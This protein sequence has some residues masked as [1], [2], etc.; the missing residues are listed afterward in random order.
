MDFKQGLHLGQRLEQRLVMT[1]Q[2]QQAIRLLQLSRA[3]LVEQ[4]RETLNENPLLE[5]QASLDG[6][7]SSSTVTGG[8]GEVTSLDS[9]EGSERE[10]SEIDWQEYFADLARGPSAQTG[11]Y[12]SR[13]DELPPLTQTLTKDQTLAEE[14]HDQLAVSGLDEQRLDIANEVIGN[15]DD[16]GY[17]RPARLQLRGGSD[18]G[19]RLLKR[20]AEQ[21]GI[22]TVDERAAL[23]LLWLTDA[24]V[25]EWT[26]EGDGRGMKAFVVPGNSTRAIAELHGVDVKMV[27]EVLA[28]IRK[29]E[30]VGV[31]SRD[32]R[33]CLLTQALVE[34]P[35][36]EKLQR[37]I[38]KHLHHLE[39]R[40]TGPILRDLKLKA[41]QVKEL[42]A[43]L[44]TL[45][46]R[47]G[48]GY[49]GESA[50]YITPDVYVHKVGDDYTIVVNDDGLPKLRVSNFYKRALAGGEARE[51]K[52]YLQEKMRQ[53]VWMIRS[54]QQRQN[55]IQKVTESIMR[56]QRPFLDQGVA[57]LRPLVLRQVAEDVGLHESTVS[58]VT[59]AKYVHTPQGIFEL[60]Y[61]FNSRIETRS[62]HDMASEAVKHAIKKLIDREQG[63]A[64]LSD[65]EIAELLQG[66]WDR[67]KTLS[68]LEIDEHELGS[69]LPE[70]RM[71]IARRTVAKYR[72][73]LNIASSSRRRAMF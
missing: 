29:C 52:D 71:N 48:R 37:L 64:P 16:D 33:E 45:E 60:K 10:R 57:A 53:A 41:H 51:A 73:A 6:A 4:V 36:D 11:S 61:F 18:A 46:P 34:H 39:E 67:G 72:E 43:K 50:R 22:E 20:K 17:F 19:R 44:Q 2:L 68:R 65:Q 40:K 14:L 27:H 42:L 13:D 30:P 21:R 3:E 28:V 24:E 35:D 25:A 63:R 8:E 59:T 1:Q 69:V 62:G 70:R 7:S 31:A 5:E 58:R 32:L 26:E 56:F 9:R 23:V 12:R 54:I 66:K 47:P 15:L 49:S 55:T 38:S